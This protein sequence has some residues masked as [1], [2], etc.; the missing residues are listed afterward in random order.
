M[1]DWIMRKKRTQPTAASLLASKR[2]VVAICAAIAMVLGAMS[3]DATMHTFSSSTAP[4]TTQEPVIKTVA[5]T[6]PPDATN[7]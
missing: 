6:P 2:I 5:P 4:N 1:K 3:V 7:N